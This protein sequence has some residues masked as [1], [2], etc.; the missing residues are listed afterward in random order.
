MKWEELLEEKRNK[1]YLRYRLGWRRGARNRARDEE[2]ERVLIMLDFARMKR[3]IKEGKFEVLGE[4]R[5]RLR[6]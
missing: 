1:M 2:E 5:Y 3:M 4:R 6:L